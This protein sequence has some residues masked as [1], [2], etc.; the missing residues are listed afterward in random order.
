MYMFTKARGGVGPESE[1]VLLV[2]VFIFCVKHI[3]ILQS[4]IFLFVV[5]HFYLTKLGFNVWSGTD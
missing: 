4:V 3:P 2:I 1:V 5:L